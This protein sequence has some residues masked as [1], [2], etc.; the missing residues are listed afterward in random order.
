LRALEVE[1]KARLKQPAQVEATAA[2]LGTFVEAVVKEDIYFRPVGDA[3]PVPAKRYRL[4]REKGQATVTFKQKIEANRVEV[5]D[6]VEFGVDDA[7]AFFRFVDFLG[8]E[9]FVRK[10]KRCRVYRLGRVN[11]ELNEVNHVGH[12]IEIEILCQAEADIPLARLE[13]SQILTKLGLNESDLEPQ[14]YIALIQA[15]H[16]VTYRYLPG[17]N[18][19]WP[20]AEEDLKHL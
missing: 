19:E 16:P 13:I 1:L 2:R 18:S 17:D 9:P 10:H 5:N 14:R 6:E 12:F 15:A 3:N 20:F 7:R 11:V 4:R 8:F